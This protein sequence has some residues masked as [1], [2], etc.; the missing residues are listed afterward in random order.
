M[1]EQ[2]AVRTIQQTS[3]KWKLLQLVGVVAIIVGVV[4]CASSM[5]DPD[6][7][8][9]CTGISWLIGAPAIIVGKLGA[10]WHHA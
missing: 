9:S 1:A 4:S 7:N 8:M 3:K 6:P 2:E 10:W 5:S